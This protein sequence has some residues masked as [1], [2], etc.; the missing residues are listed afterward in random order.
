MSINNI[1]NILF[2]S[3]SHRCHPYILDFVVAASSIGSYFKIYHGEQVTS[4]APHL[5][6]GKPMYPTASFEG[7]A[8]GKSVEFVPDDLLRA[9]FLHNDRS[10]PIPY[11]IQ[12]AFTQI[13]GAATDAMAET[14]EGLAQAM[15]TGFWE[16][17]LAA[18]EM[19]HG[20]R[21]NEN[22]PA[23]LKFA[24]V[25]RDTMSH[26]GVLNMY[27]SVPPVSHFNL[28]YEKTNNGRKIIHND[29]TCADIFFLM[30]AVNAE[31]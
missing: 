19:A 26:G 8:S 10:Q 24:A 29:L 6:N 23:V 14:L 4:F 27:S 9:V 30:L 2:I 11:I 12:P 18:I 13:S 28:T 7:K 17:N 31:F 20:K 21:K 16:N 15:F 1:P 25:I 5:S 22:W 3:S